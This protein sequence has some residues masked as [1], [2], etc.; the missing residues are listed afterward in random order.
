MGRYGYAGIL[1]AALS[2]AIV[3]C[4][5]E[6]Y[7]VAAASTADGSV[8]TALHLSPGDVKYQAPCVVA[9]REVPPA[10]PLSCIY[11]QTNTGMH[12]LRFTPGESKYEPAASLQFTELTG[13]ALAR[14]GF[15]REIQVERR[16][17][18]FAFHIVGAELVN[19]HMTKD[20]FQSLSDA[21]IPKKAPQP[22]INL[23]DPM[24][25]TIT[26]PIYVGR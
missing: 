18:M 25:V 4:T 23:L 8:L 2:F 15:N 5:S 17:E 21:G 16:D 1:L 20:I 22:W 7:R 19:T 14:L 6:E 3:G 13:I 11:V 24:G 12:F 26:I 9:V 10:R